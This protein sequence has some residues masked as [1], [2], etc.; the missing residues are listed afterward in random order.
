MPTTKL[1]NLLY[2]AALPMAA[3]SPRGQMSQISRGEPLRDLRGYHRIQFR[4]HVLGSTLMLEHDGK[5]A[6]IDTSTTKSPA[7]HAGEG[8]YYR[9]ASITKMATSLVTLMLVQEGCFAL[10][11]PVSTLLPG[12]DRAEALRGVTVR[13]LLSHTSGLRDPADLEALLLKDTPWQEV[14]QRKDARG[15]QP[16]KQFSYCNL[17]FGLLGC[18]MEQATGRSVAA[19][20]EERLARVLGLRCTLEAAMLKDEEIMPISRVLPYRAGADVVR[21]RLGR[22]PMTAPDP[23]RHYGQTAG[24]MYITPSSL[25][26]MVRF[27][28]DGGVAEGRR[29][30]NEALVREM[31]TEQAAYGAISPGMTYGLGLLRLDEP[32][33]SSHR[34]LGHQGFAYGCADGAF[35]EENTGNIVIFVNGGCSEARTG[36]LGLC[37][38]DVLRWALKEEMPRWP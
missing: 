9:V 34:L 12:G 8:T 5:T 7:H 17:G 24:G 19:V 32:T 16:G 35:W 31:I 13:Q 37:N 10:D 33:I 18:M 15:S 2:C 1:R 25:L 20:F 11:T 22:Q 21:T 30:L 4:H 29:L 23:E 3:P 27:L 28:R 38:R 36:R 6:C 14:L 26:K